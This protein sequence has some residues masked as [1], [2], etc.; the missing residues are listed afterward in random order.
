MLWEIWEKFAGKNC[1]KCSKSTEQLESINNRFKLI[2]SS[3]LNFRFS[4]FFYP[5]WKCDGTNNNNA[6][7]SQR[8]SR[9]WL[10]A[11]KYWRYIACK[12]YTTTRQPSSSDDICQ[13]KRTLQDEEWININVNKNDQEPRAKCI[14]K[15][16]AVQV[17]KPPIW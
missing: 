17:I 9:F 6:I 10:R 2:T 7:G 1:N 13:Q 12:C 16:R 3:M 11:F 8:Q 14:T 4:L 15:K 5:L